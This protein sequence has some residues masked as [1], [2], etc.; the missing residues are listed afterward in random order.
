MKPKVRKRST[1]IDKSFARL[2]KKDTRF[3]LL[4]SRM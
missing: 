3:E 2:R 1:K 4:K